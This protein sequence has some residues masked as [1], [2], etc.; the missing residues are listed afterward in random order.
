MI[1]ARIYQASVGRE[2]D[3][4]DVEFKE[5]GRIVH[6]RSDKRWK[7]MIVAKAHL[8]LVYVNF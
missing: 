6:P 4:S 8:Y 7:M 1:R 5:R 2:L 3:C